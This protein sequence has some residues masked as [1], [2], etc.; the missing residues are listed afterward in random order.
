MLFYQQTAEDTLRELS[1]SIEGISKYQASERLKKYGPNE[2]KLKGEPLWKKLIEPFANVF[3]A[4]LFVAVLISFW[5]NAVLDAIIILVIMLTS[6]A[7]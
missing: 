7:I 2:I 1:S 5:H 4:V 6:A 3:M